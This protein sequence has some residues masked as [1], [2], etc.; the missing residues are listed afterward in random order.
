MK[1]NPYVGT[2]IQKLSN[3]IEKCV[4]SKLNL[5]ENQ[6]ISYKNY[7]DYQ[8]SF[9]CS[10]GGYNGGICKKNLIIIV[11]IHLDYNHKFTGNI[12]IISPM[13]L[14]SVIQSVA[15]KKERNDII[16]ANDA[17]HQKLAGTICKVKHVDIEKYKHNISEF[18]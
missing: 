2:K 3:D 12:Y 7:K 8:D 13:E 11:F 16:I 15:N 10:T 9:T 5:R 14:M 18:I 4:A 6:V 1:N 17:I